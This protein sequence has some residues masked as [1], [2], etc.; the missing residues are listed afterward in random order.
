MLR[1]PLN[2][3]AFVLLLGLVALACSSGTAQNDSRPYCDRA[4]GPY[5][6][7]RA[8]YAAYCDAM[9]RCGLGKELGFAFACRQECVQS[10]DFGS[11]C[12][13]ADDEYDIDRWNYQLEVR[14]VVY[15]QEMGKECIAWWD[16]ADCT[17]VKESLH[18]VQYYDDD[19][20]LPEACQNALQ[21]PDEGGNPLAGTVGEGEVCQYD[22]EC[23]EELYCGRPA[24]IGDE[25]C[26]TCQPYPGP[27]E[28]CHNGWCG[29][30]AYCDYNSDP[31]MCV[32]QSAAGQACENYNHCLS[33]RCYQD[34][35]ID[36]LA[37]DQPCDD[38]AQ[39]ESSFCYEGNC[40]TRREE[41]GPCSENVEC[42]T[43][44][45]FENHCI[46]I[47]RVGEPCEAHAYCQYSCYQ[48]LCIDR[49]ED[50][51]PCDEDLNCRS[52]STCYLGTCVN[53]SNLP[54]GAPCEQDYTCGLGPCIEGLCTVWKD[55]GESC[56]VAEVCLCGI[57]FEGAC[58]LPNGEDCHQHSNCRSQRCPNNLF[59]VDPL[60][61]GEPCEWD[62]ECASWICMDGECFTYK[63]TDE[64]CQTTSQCDSNYTIFCDPATLTCQPTRYS[65]EP[66]TVDDACRKE[67]CDLL[68]GLCGI[69]A[70]EPCSWDNECQGYCDTDTSLCA[71][72]KTDTED[73]NR[74]EQCIHYCHYSR[75][76]QSKPYGAECVYDVECE[77]GF[78]S[79][80]YNRYRCRGPGECFSHEDC[81]ADSWCNEDD[82]PALCVALKTDGESC[83]EDA[84]CENYCYYN[85]MEQKPSGAPCD[86]DEECWDN[87]CE[88]GSCT[89]PGLCWSDSDCPEEQFC[90]YSLYDPMCTDPKP[91]GS[92]CE[93]DDD[94]LSGWCSPSDTCKIRPTLGEPCQYWE[95]TLDS[96]CLNGTCE[97]RKM[98]GAACDETFLNDAECLVPSIC[99]N[100]KCETISLECVPAEPG[101]MCT[102]L[103]ACSADAYCDLMDGFTCK[104]RSKVGESCVTTIWRVDTCMAGSHCQEEKCVA[105]ASLGDSCADS[106]CDPHEGYCDSGTCQSLKYGGEL[107]TDDA[108]CL[109][110][111]CEYWDQDEYRCYGPC[112]QPE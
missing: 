55:Y 49:R 28:P 89:K 74:D 103:M 83:E 96:Y 12:G 40:F 34:I 22:N 26:T 1:N 44:R 109:G 45:C 61:D 6:E 23:Q 50:S 11:T 87:L 73:C 69:P 108:E 15:D 16:A 67:F 57:C 76:L 9:E 91:D 27:G 42:A 47:Y 8:L 10:F 102:F 82:F 13:I 85:C 38:N 32:A 104:R 5:T 30:G 46:P 95:C 75:C 110:G 112:K 41:G 77:G 105:Y 70:G 36:P 51:E 19:S 111:D 48:G 80:D 64:V 2:Y 90:D 72:L 25:V 24:N 78:C 86:A 7:E 79:R 4:D 107:C 60:A 68:A 63:K 66:C 56:T 52:D 106:V 88:N 92:S 97:L 93:Y 17:L 20:R 14:Q 71:D 98:P 59:C 101:E 65:G 31:G 3:C 53:S 62:E 100:G 29:P 39:C 21:I 43:N 33:N 35:C 18:S 81:D 54:E 94:C 84:E 58:G 99:R 37:D